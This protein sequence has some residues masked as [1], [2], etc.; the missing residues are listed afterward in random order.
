MPREIPRLREETVKSKKRD[1]RGLFKA[2]ERYSSPTLG[3]GLATNPSK[4][5]SFP[6]N[7]IRINFFWL[8]LGQQ[9]HLNYDG[10]K[11]GPKLG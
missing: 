10:N 6:N 3:F 4:F 5:D 1:T 8:P 7:L 11:S 9:H 2:P